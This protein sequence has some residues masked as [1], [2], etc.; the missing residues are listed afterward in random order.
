[1]DNNNLQENVDYFSKDKISS[2]RGTYS[3]P[4]NHQ[5]FHHHQLFPHF[6]KFK[7]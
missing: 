1:M 4:H 3:L 7:T 6:F 2:N 5:L